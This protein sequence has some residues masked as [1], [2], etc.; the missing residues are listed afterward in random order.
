MNAIYLHKHNG[1]KF[2]DALAQLNQDGN[3]AAFCGFVRYASDIDDADGQREVARELFRAFDREKEGGW[4]SRVESAVPVLEQVFAAG[5]NPDWRDATG[6]TLLHHAAA[7]GTPHRAG[8]ACEFLADRGVPTLACDQFGC[9]AVAYASASHWMGFDVLNDVL[10][11]P[12]TNSTHAFCRALLANKANPNALDLRSG[13][14]PLHQV[15]M[16]PEGEPNEFTK[17]SNLVTTL[18]K[19]GAN[20]NALTPGGLTPYHLASVGEQT[21]LLQ[22]QLRNS[23]ADLSIRDRDGRTAA[24]LELLS[25]TDKKH[26]L[27]V[28]P[29]SLSE[30]EAVGPIDEGFDE[31]PLPLNEVGPDAPVSVPA[32]ESRKPVVAGAAGE[33]TFGIGGIRP[34]NAPEPAAPRRELA[35]PGLAPADGQPELF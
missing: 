18:L 22:K 17:M 4:L 10:A 7:F 6:K 16:E 11:Q 27:E 23:G 26:L 8:T 12:M 28:K 35:A 1:V 32:P 5:F 33:L 29:H 14:R 30:M 3:A 24:E 2:T 20:P 19:A 31:D 34:P 21:D 15:L 25:H 9:Q 13:L